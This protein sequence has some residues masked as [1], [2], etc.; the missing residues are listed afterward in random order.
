MGKF[1][2]FQSLKIINLRYYIFLTKIH[3]Q[4]HKRSNFINHNLQIIIKKN[5]AYIEGGCYTTKI[6]NIFQ[7]GIRI[8]PLVGMYLLKIE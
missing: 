3:L 6:P 5:F 8:F 7:I 4:R 1:I 2:N